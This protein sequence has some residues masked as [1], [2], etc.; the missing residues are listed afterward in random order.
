M[1]VIIAA[2]SHLWIQMLS[3][4]DMQLHVAMKECQR[5]STFMTLTPGF[6]ARPSSPPVFGCN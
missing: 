3:M 1:V 2:C 4:S 5:V 6:T